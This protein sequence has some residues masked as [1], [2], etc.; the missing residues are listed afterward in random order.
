MGDQGWHDSVC[1]N[2][3]SAFLEN[4]V[5]ALAIH[6]QSEGLELRV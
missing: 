5:L 3:I 6:G 1:S 4:P 2:L